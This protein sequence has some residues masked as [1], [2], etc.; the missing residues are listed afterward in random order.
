LAWIFATAVFLVA[1][2][3]LVRFSRARK[4]AFMGFVG[5][6]VIAVV[7]GGAYHLYDQN[8]DAMTKRLIGRS[9]LA[10][11]SVHLERETFS[12]T[13]YRIT[14]DVTNKSAHPLASF[15]IHASAEDCPPGRSCITIGEADCHVF[16]DVPPGQKRGFTGSFYLTNLP[17]HGELKWTFEAREIIGQID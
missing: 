13:S 9:D 8:R 15:V 2:F 4:I 7:G 17:A 11:G 10:F 14:S 3:V 5:V 1:V 16:V 12:D 6:A